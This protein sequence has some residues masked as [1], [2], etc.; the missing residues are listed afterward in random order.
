MDRW[1]DMKRGKG[2]KEF[3]RLVAIARKGLRR[4]IQFRDNS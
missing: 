3:L 1:I 4:K 2:L